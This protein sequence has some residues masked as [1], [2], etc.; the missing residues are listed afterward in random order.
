LRQ[1]KELTAIF[2]SDMACTAD[3]GKSLMAL[4]A[5]AYSENFGSQSLA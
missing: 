4:E 1:R 3:V 2:N 5:S